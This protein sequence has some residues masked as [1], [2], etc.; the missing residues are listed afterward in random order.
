MYVRWGSTL[1]TSF[2]VTNGVRQ[3]RILS[4]M[5]FNLYINN[6]SI[7]LTNSGIGGTL[8]VKFVNHIIYADDLCI[9]SLSSS[10]LKT[11]LKMCTYYCDLHD[12]KFNAKTSVCLVSSLLSTKVVLY[13]KFLFV[14]QYVNFRMKSS[15]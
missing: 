4:P 15:I 5:L 1:S 13:S 3:G 14:I 9:V 8:R 7:R 12:I 6:L 2:Q 10:G 11:L